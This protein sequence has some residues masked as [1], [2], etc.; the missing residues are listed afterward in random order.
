MG[1]CCG[2]MY[3]RLIP[4]LRPDARLR[5]DQ[6]DLGQVAKSTRTMYTAWAPDIPGLW[7]PVVHANCDHNLLLAL[8]MRSLGPTPEPVESGWTALRKSFRKLSRLARRYSGS[9]WTLRQTAESYKG[10][11]GRRYLAAEESLMLDGSLS[12]RDIMLDCFLKAEKIK[13]TGKFPKPR[14]IFPRSPRY[15][16]LLASWLKPF[17]HWLWGNL[18]SIGN[19]GVPKSR[20]VAKGLS[21][22]QRA[23]LIVRKFSAFRRCLVFEV[24]G[25]AF[26]AHLSRRHL[27]LEH[28]VY[29]AAYRS[30]GELSR[31]LSVQERLVGVAGNGLRFERDG[32]RASGDFN[33][34]MGNTLSMVAFIDTIMTEL[35]VRYDSLSD[36][37]NALLFLE[38]ADSARVLERFSD[39]GTALTGQE[40]VLER[41]VEFIEGIRFGQSAPVW[42]GSKWRMVRD[43]RKVLSQGTSSHM[44]LHDLRFAP[45]YLA[46]VARCEW[47]LNRGLPILGTWS[48]TL[49]DWAMSHG[50]GVAAHGYRDYEY[51]GVDVDRLIDPISEE[52]SD[53]ARWS[54]ERAFG[55]TPD[56]QILVEQLLH[57]PVMREWDVQAVPLGSN[58]ELHPAICH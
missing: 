12:S 3:K 43:W 8:C 2:D 22:V 50:R 54:F 21:P 24:D 55:T 13:A 35:N 18:K 44:H 31:L 17:E 9:R 52:V 25:K 26:E 10:A 37:D 58:L 53:E 49:W 29:L 38:V 51:L 47:S 27:L 40:F 7:H 48:K 1:F 56:E 15:N 42:D 23:G 4:T 32:G 39:L 6:R 11:L 5:Y 33:T 30:P 16:L 34:G 19:H 45:A 14:V 20:V 28:G 41:P 57:P 46:G 36:G